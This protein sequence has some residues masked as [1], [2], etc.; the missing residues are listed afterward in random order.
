MGV[1]SM[2]PECRDRMVMFV[3]LSKEFPK[4]CAARTHPTVFTARA[5]FDRGGR[6][7]QRGKVSRLAM[8]GLL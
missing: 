8:S 3:I 6:V 7:C 2:R 5:P 4:G 1:E